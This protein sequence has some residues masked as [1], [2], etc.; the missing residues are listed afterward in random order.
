MNRFCCTHLLSMF[1][2][3]TCHPH[4]HQLSLTI[5]P[6]LNPTRY[7][8]LSLSLWV[9]QFFIALDG[10]RAWNV[11]LSGEKVPSAKPT[12]P[13]HSVPILN[14]LVC[15]Y[16]CIMYIYTYVCIYVCMYVCLYVHTYVR[17]YVYVCVCV[18]VCMHAF[19]YIYM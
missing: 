8:S 15:M 2:S 12:I 1:L 19:M 17:I 5:W 6:L 9:S 4:S 3:M 11:G 13:D 18:C 7:L 10:L 14:I 16:V